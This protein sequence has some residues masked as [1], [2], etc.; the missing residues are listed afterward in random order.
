MW[1]AEMSVKLEDVDFGAGPLFLVSTLSVHDYV[2][3]A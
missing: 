1:V 2:K 3:V